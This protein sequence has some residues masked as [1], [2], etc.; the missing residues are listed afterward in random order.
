MW[1]TI[2][3]L[4][5]VHTS[6][7]HAFFYTYADPK[8]NEISVRQLGASLATFEVSTSLAYTGGGVI[9]SFDVS[10]RQSTSGEFRNV[11]S[12]T[13]TS[14]GD[15]LVWTGTFTIADADLDP[16]TGVENIQFL[17]F[18]NNQFGYKSNGSIVSG[19]YDLCKMIYTTSCIHA[20]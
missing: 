10:Y 20:I 3:A 6:I 19:I 8:V 13:A 16:S 11:K 5:T 9:N 2:S 17:V 1:L 4:A 15:L 7:S 14:S 18:V 12:V